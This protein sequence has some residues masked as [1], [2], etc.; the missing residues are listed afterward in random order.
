MWDVYRLCSI[1]NSSLRRFATLVVAA[2][3]SVFLMNIFVAPFAF[4]ADVEWDGSNLKYQG[5]VYVPE[6][7]SI[8]GVPAGSQAFVFK[9]EPQGV[10]HVIYFPAATDM[11]KDI[12]ATFRSFNYSAG[13]YSNPQ[14]ERPIA[15]APKAGASSNPPNSA[16]GETTQCAIKGV[17]WIVCSLSRALASGMD[18]IFEWIAG[19][20]E[21]RPVTSDTS[22]ALYGTW[23][24][25]RSFANIAFVVAFLII[26]YSQITNAGLNN[27][28]IKKM[29]PR[30]IVA[31]I[32]VNLSYY[33][34]AIAVDISN[35]LGHSLQQ[36]LIDIRQQ[37]N[38]QG[39]SGISATSWENITEYILSGGTLAAAG[40]VGVMAF[41]GG[42]G[43]SITALSA[44]L[45]PM[46]VAGAA[47][48]LVALIV[49][50]AR[51]A[52]ITVLIVLAP[53]AFVAYLLPNTEKWFDKWRSLFMTMLL[54][55]P[56]FSL[57]FG[58][59][60]LASYI[61]LQNA[62][63]W[64]VVLLALF[65]QVA[66]LALTPFLVKFS[67]S[68]LGRFAGMVNNP[69][70]GL[71]DRTRNWAK[72]RAETQ[73]KR[74]R[75]LGAQ[76][77]GPI[78]RMAYRRES[79]RLNR[80]AAKE[81]GDKRVAAKW[82]HDPRNHL[83][84]S[85]SGMADLQKSAGEAASEHQFEAYK[86]TS[87]TAQNY[88]GMQRINKGASANIQALEEA[89][90]EEAKSRAV[91]A[92][93]PFQQYATQAQAQVRQANIA[94]SKAATGKALQQIE[95]ASDL[96]NNE[97]IA[98]A[99]GGIDYDGGADSA[100]AGALNTLRK[101][102]QDS[103]SEA[104]ALNKH[105][106]LSSGDRQKLAEGITVIGTDDRGRTR[107]FTADTVYAREAAVY[108]QVKMGT[109]EEAQS[110]ILRSG[111]RSPDG[112]YK[113]REAISDAMVEG[114]LSGKANYLGGKTIDDVR[115]GRI[116]GGADILRAALTSIAKGKLSP[117]QLLQQDKVSME[118]IVEAIKQYTNGQI[119]LDNDEHREALYTELPRLFGS[120]HRAMTDTRIN[121]RLGERAGPMQQLYDIG[122]NGTPMTYPM[123]TPPPTPPPMPPTND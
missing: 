86:A 18:R 103:V 13:T 111:D 88:I 65:V 105:F 56:M 48:V 38:G 72:D 40:V 15:I 27:Y 99:A 22:T 34:C 115:A 76:G 67:G 70:K 69:E 36:A 60:Q 84:H 107:E 43:G 121:A 46:L 1:G 104:R 21:V 81:L 112:L 35:I 98:K 9:Q 37:F 63:Q 123:G 95:Y 71:V 79:G 109:V 7:A 74:S 66:P 30:L 116:T 32:L 52:I 5:Q 87:K 2:L 20:L 108:D 23:E 118:T 10:A 101:S 58:G 14:V 54:V 47:A 41:T 80:E 17:G 78:R 45:V 59:S 12:P 89:R 117:E 68:L 77:R 55:F 29:L 39:S 106:N 50:A 6:S 82:A 61:I 73:A 33:I 113:Y 94:A 100:I 19:F 119:Y 64:S 11:T 3:V 90:W 24:I 93:N 44:L 91:S 16:Q 42:L 92:D 8:A 120:A 26:I 31:A 28:S 110:L 51:Q 96:I 97:A 62:S 4:A 114:G 25:M 75:G 102:H 83:L 57:L 53:L 122:V 49:L 85:Q